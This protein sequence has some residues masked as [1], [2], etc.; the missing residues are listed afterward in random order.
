[1]DLNQITHIGVLGAGLMG[2]GIAQIF[3]S[4][5]YDV[6]LYDA[7]AAALQAAKGRIA[8]NFKVFIELKLARPEDRDR[9]L[10]RIRL[11]PSLEAFVRGPQFIIEAVLE[12]LKIKR[13]L[14]RSSSR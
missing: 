3:A 14:Y 13:N 5:G 2:H 12:D 11:C 7:D 10:D 6:N 8:D 4:S 9:C 1:M